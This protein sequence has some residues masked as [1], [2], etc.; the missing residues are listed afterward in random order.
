MNRKTGRSVVSSAF[1]GGEGIHTAEYSMQADYEADLAYA[2]DV[3]ATLTAGVA[4]KP[5]VNPPGRRQEDD[6][7]VVAYGLGKDDTVAGTI[8]AHAGG[9]RTT[10]I[11]NRGAYVHHVFHMTQDPISSETTSPALTN[12]NQQ[13]CAT[14]GVSV[15]GT[16]AHTLKAEGFDGSEDGTG[17]GMPIVPQTAGLVRRL[18]PTEC[19]R[20]QGF[21]DGHTVVDKAAVKAMKERW[22]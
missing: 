12:G 3:A 11:D 16:V 2:P 4:T 1:A 21:P 10:D 13:G 22:A 8:G 5:G 14:V 6:T 15:T 18:T 7:N 19:E 9:G 20:L 17:R